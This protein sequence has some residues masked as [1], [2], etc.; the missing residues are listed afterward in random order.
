MPSRH[1]FLALLTARLRRHFSRVDWG[2][3]LQ[4][5]PGESVVLV[6]L[7]ADLDESESALAAGETVL[8]LR[9]TA[10]TAPLAGRREGLA[11][12]LA[13]AALADQLYSLA[14]EDGLALNGTGVRVQAVPG[15]W[16]MNYDWAE[17]NVRIV[18]LAASWWLNL[19]AGA[20][21]VQEED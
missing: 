1:D 20:P 4:V 8:T 3:D 12:E 6:E 16:Q 13:A 18:Q 19:A 15:A 14:I 9:L 21:A 2:Q 17:Q 11:V 5:S 7:I 10:G